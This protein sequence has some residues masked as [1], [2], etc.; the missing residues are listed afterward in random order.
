MRIQGCIKPPFFEDTAVSRRFAVPFFT[1]LTDQKSPF[2]AA[3][4]LVARINYT[5]WGNSISHVI[6]SVGPVTRRPLWTVFCGRD[7]R[8]VLFLKLF[9]KQA[10]AGRAPSR[11]IGISGKGARRPIP[12]WKG[13]KPME[14]TPAAM[15]GNA[16]SMFLQEDIAKRGQSLPAKYE[17]S[18]RTRRPSS[19]LPQAEL[20]KLC[21]VD[22]CPSGSC[23]RRT[24]AAYI[25]AANL[26]P[27]LLPLC[28]KGPRAFLYC[29]L[30]LA[31]GACGGLVGMSRSAVSGAGQSR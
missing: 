8:P 27:R 17:P 29:A 2:Q 12:S 18:A 20:D 28:R 7:G 21:A 4:G 19:G 22:R 23:S 14:S 26:R 24:A 16:G 3:E 30:D 1:R 5:L 15:A 25:S 10:L 9:K 31:G 6:A 11:R 13:V